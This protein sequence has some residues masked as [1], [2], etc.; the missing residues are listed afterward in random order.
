MEKY[1]PQQIYRLSAF[2]K[3]ARAN[4]YVVK[5]NLCNGDLIM[6]EKL[7]KRRRSGFVKNDVKVQNF[8][9]FFTLSVT[10]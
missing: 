10:I 6:H 1:E 2:G 3:K 8:S 5:K 4:E 7:D 9:K